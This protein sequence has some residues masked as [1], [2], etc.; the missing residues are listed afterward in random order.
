[1]WKCCGLN[2]TFL[3]I[4]ILGIRLVLVIAV[5]NQKAHQL[6]DSLQTDP[7]S[8]SN[9][10]KAQLVM[11]GPIISKR[12]RVLSPDYARGQVKETGEGRLV[13]EQVST[14]LP[15]HPSAQHLSYTQTAV[16]YSLSS[17]GGADLFNKDRRRILRAFR[18]RA[19]FKFSA[20][21]KQSR[22]AKLSTTDRRAPG[23]TR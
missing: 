6:G 16:Y 23:S 14:I 21:D 7:L 3:Y 9:C 15:T 10:T 18:R 2:A 4:Q 1:M 22:D 13:N 11:A 8:V 17:K 5:R 12:L 20:C 19:A